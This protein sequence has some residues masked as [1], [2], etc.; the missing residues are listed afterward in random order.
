[1]FR[2]PL[3]TPSGLP[4]LPQ[5]P[6]ETSG[7]TRRGRSGQRPKKC[8]TL[9]ARA[10][11]RQSKTAADAFFLTVFDRRSDCRKA[12]A[13]RWR[14]TSNVWAGFCIAFTP[15][16]GLVAKNFAALPGGT[17]E[18]THPPTEVTP[19]LRPRPLTGA[20]NHKLLLL[21]EEDGKGQLPPKGG[22]RAAAGGT[23]LKGWW[24]GIDKK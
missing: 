22:C 2:I 21:G 9:P 17:F 15:H 16:G 4:T 14:V 6:E 24:V 13:V 19:G 7:L 10:N 11:H 1:M 3:P 20:L 5:R 12:P 18:P 8:D 23:H